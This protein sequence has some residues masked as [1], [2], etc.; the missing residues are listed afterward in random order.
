MFLE[1]WPTHTKRIIHIHM[2]A[3]F[4]GPA[5][6]R[7][8]N[9]NHPGESPLQRGATRPT[10]FNLD[11]LK[12]SPQHCISNRPIKHHSWTSPSHFKPSTPQEHP[13]ALTPRRSL[14][15][16]HVGDGGWVVR[17]RSSRSIQGP[18]LPSADMS[19]LIDAS[20]L[21]R[22]DVAPT[23]PHGGGVIKT[24]IQRHF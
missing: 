9:R 1:F 5:A 7:K 18:T 11:R 14:H 24:T 8:A 13:T 2:D 10:N 3:T 19:S 4:L 12:G 15:G 17:A 6:N 22:R 21:R 16:M 20:F 23:D